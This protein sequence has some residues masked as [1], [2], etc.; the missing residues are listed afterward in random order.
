LTG[1]NPWII[2]VLARLEHLPELVAK[3]RAV[4]RRLLIIERAG[5]DCANGTAL[6]ERIHQPYAREG[7]PTGAFRLAMVAARPRAGG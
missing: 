4:N 7:Q 3:A 1:S 5:Q 2:G 6:F